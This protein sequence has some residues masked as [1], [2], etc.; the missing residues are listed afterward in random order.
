MQDWTVVDLFCGI[1]GLA[2]GFVQEGF[3]VSAGIDLDDTCK[4]AF[5]SN[6][7]SRFVQRNVEL[8]TSSELVQTFGQSRRRILVGC[9]PCQ[10]FSK[11]TVAQS[12]DRKWHLL[13]SFLRLIVRVQPEIVSME[14]VPELE[15]HVV[16][17]DF[18]ER[19][20]EVGYYV[21]ECVVNASEYGVPQSRRRLVLFG[22]KFGKVTLIKP[23]HY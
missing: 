11:Y 15:R 5:E 13:K 1:G 14:N 4:Y 7:H 18:V 2:H 21:T 8:L 22:S 9:A 3:N 6:N 12:E 23:T 20:E 19:L 10:P 16:F 17:Q